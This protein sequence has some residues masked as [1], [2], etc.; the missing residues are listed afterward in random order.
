[1]RLRAL[2]KSEETKLYDYLGTK[3][4]VREVKR[5][6]NDLAGISYNEETGTPCYVC[7]LESGAIVT[8]NGGD[9]YLKFRDYDPVADIIAVVAPNDY[10]YNGQGIVWDFE[11]FPND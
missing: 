10:R 2:T 1:M 4:E 9:P 5:M 3:R 8:Y 7:C 6:I 11:I